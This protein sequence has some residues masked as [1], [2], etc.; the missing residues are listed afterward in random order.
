[1]A[2]RRPLIKLLALDTLVGYCQASTLGQAFAILR[3]VGFELRALALCP[4]LATLAAML[5]KHLQ[6]VAADDE[7]A[8]AIVA[9]CGRLGVPLRGGGPPAGQALVEKALVCWKLI[10]APPPAYLKSEYVGAYDRAGPPVMDLER[11]EGNDFFQNDQSCARSFREL[12]RQAQ[13]RV[14]Q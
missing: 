9:A 2:H 3:R 8:S 6:L 5:R 14:R 1:M 4:S 10:G 12:V 13:A 11:N 7:A